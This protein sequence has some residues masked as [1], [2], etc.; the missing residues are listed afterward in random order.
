MPHLQISCLGLFQAKLDNQPITSFESGKVR[1]LLVYLVLEAGEPHSRDELIGLLWPDRPE[2]TARANLRQAVANLREAIGDHAAQPPFLLIVG[3]TLQFNRQSDYELDVALFDDQLQQCANHMHRRLGACPVCAEHLR[4]GIELYRGDFLTR[5]YQSSQEFDEW[6]LLVRERL[7]RAA[8][9]ALYHLADYH[10]R[11]ANYTAVQQYA[12]RQ[13]ELDPWREEAH[14]QVMRALALSGQRSAA[15]AQYEK[16]SRLLA[17]ELDLEPSSATKDLADQ[18]KLGQL[19][20]APSVSALPVTS[21]PL[22]GRERELIEIDHQLADP[23][24]HLLSIV[25]PGGVGKT[26]LALQVASTHAGAFGHGV[27]VISLVT[28][29]TRTQF[30]AML[31]QALGLSLGDTD[32][33][34]WQ[35]AYY[36]ARKEI[37]IVIDNSEQLSTDGVEVLAYL[38]SQAPQVVFMVTANERLNLYEERVLVLQGLGLPDLNHARSPEQ[39]AQAEAVQLLLS[40]AQ[41]ARHDFQPQA[42]DWTALA[43]LSHFLMGVPLALEL[44]AGW[45]DTLGVTGL[46][47]ELQRDVSLLNMDG[48]NV[49]MRHRHLN[50]IFEYSW[51]R[52]SAEDRL[53]LN[54]FTIFRGGFTRLAA[55]QVV[56]IMTGTAASLQV[57]AN[58]VHKSLLMYDR[59]RDRYDCHELLRRFVSAQVIWDEAQQRMAHQAH[60]NYYCSFL[61]TRQTAF[62]STRQQAI[63]TEVEADIANIRLAWSW[64]VA[65]QDVHNIAI[66]LEGLFYL[67]D[68]RSQFMEGETAF[69]EAAHSLA[70]RPANAEQL[71]TLA[72][73]ETRQGWFT[74]HLGR[75][76]ESLQLIRRSLIQ[77]QQYQDEREEAFSLHYLGAVLRHLGQ[78]QQANDYLSQALQLAQH[79]GERY[80]VSMCL[81][82]LGQMAWLQGDQELAQ[83]YC[84]EGLQL[85]REIGDQRGMM[86]SLI[87]LGRV[88]E[89]QGEFDQAQHLFEESMKVSNLTGDRRGMVLA[90]QN[91]GDVAV[92]QQHY[93]EAEEAYQRSIMTSR[94]IGDRLGLSL[95]LLRL[96]EVNIRCGQLLSGKASLREGLQVALEIGSGPTLIDGLLG[97]TK[98]W[99]AANQPNRAQDCLSF[100]ERSSQRSYVQHLQAQQLRHELESLSIFR[101]TT[102]QDIPNDKNIEVFV[103]ERVLLA[104][105]P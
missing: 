47:H 53:A 12:L 76:E 62:N 69:R 41:R 97:M 23:A 21:T 7:H 19:K 93:A 1:A 14:R 37:L 94:D 96:G 16:C 35:L 38:I 36:L 48:Q 51:Q 32:E 105:L 71:I 58:L 43:E 4:A 74:F 67:Y 83:R 80:L 15:L 89:V 66:S 65:H 91:L 10:E 73:L 84:T 24:C 81:N 13:V 100:V 8:L 57:L 33:P 18:I 101:L 70:S 98:L 88:L 82:T 85:K 40:A 68:I 87:Y 25:G 103:K 11:Q 45:L 39:I 50:H 95:G 42:T 5:F 56:A 59:A 52:L 30:I 9:E 104:S 17:D 102:E 55:Q 72:R 79:A 90:W 63:L 64:A 54:A 49:S 60:C 28:V 3:D 22:I 92:A 2:S 78:Y 46:L 20:L 26:R 75:P 99:L 29:T 6:A 31:A 44:A 61:Q 34:L 27:Y 77:L 86:Y